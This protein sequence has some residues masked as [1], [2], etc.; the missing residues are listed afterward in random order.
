MYYHNQLVLTGQINDVGAYTQTNVNASYRAGIELQAGVTLSKW[1][2]LYGNATFS[3]NKIDKFTEY[4]DNYDS[5]AQRTINHSNNDIAFSPNFI[6][7]ATAAFTLLKGQKGSTLGVDITGKF[8][9]KHY[10]DNTQNDDRSIKAY[11]YCNALIRYSVKTRPFKEVIATLALNNIFGS[12]YQN[13][14]YTF[15]YISGGT[16]TTQNYYYPQAGFNIMGGL[17]FRW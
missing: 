6:S 7:A 5:S 12:L 15:S 10:L 8:V 1:F 13:N 16:F 14:G 9:G 4:I 2:Q 17:T 11:N 3:Q